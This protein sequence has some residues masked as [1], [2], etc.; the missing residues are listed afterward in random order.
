MLGASG[1]VYAV[2]LAFGGYYPETRLLLFF[3]IPL[4]V[5][6][7]ILLFTVVELGLEIFNFNTGIAHLTHLFGFLFGFIYLLLIHKI[8][9]IQ[10]M[11]FKKEEDSYT[12]R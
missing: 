1:A 3:V 4:K 5:K 12:I 7:A 10:K 6:W 8:N 2:L 11:F 9:P